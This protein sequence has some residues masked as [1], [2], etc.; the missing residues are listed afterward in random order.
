MMRSVGTPVIRVG[1]VIPVDEHPLPHHTQP[2][3]GLM[4]RDNI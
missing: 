4:R 2:M 3:T 1:A